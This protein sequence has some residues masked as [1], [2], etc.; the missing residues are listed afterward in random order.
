MV[1]LL[2]LSICC[3]FNDAAVT[4]NIRLIEWLEDKNSELEKMWN[5]EIMVQFKL[6]SWHLP[7]QTKENHRDLSQD[8]WYP[9]QD[10]K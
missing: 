4:L 5:E 9:N 8:S 3:L 1:W 2:S 6:L 7:G 10:S